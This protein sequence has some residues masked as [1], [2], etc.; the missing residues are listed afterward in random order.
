MNLDKEQRKALCSSIR[1][2][3]YSR[4]VIT[5]LRDL[6]DDLYKTDKPNVLSNLDTSMDDELAAVFQNLLNNVDTSKPM[7]AEQALRA[8]ID[9]LQG[10]EEISFVVPIH[11]KNEF[12]QRLYGWCSEN[13]NDE[14]LVDFTTNRLME[15]GLLM[16]YK[17]KYFE[18]SLENLLND[19]LSSHELGK[20][21]D[22]AV[23]SEGGQGVTS[24]EVSTV[25]PVPQAEQSSEPEVVTED[26]SQPVDGLVQNEKLEE[27]VQ[28]VEETPTQPAAAEEKLDEKAPAEEKKTTND[29]QVPEHDLPLKDEAVKMP[30]IG[31]PTNDTQV[32]SSGN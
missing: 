4:K 17:G 9:F 12:V 32:A 1:T 19:Y 16:I 21:F 11:P 20:F 13:I 15:S 6:S 30:D 26:K 24:E 10:V 8:V 18:Y 29:F 14:A 25:E 2:T 7:E 31:L 28:R 22:S 3:R 27:S 23:S 5:L